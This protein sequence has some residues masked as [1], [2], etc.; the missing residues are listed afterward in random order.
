MTRLRMTLRSLPCAFAP[1]ITATSPKKTAQQTIS[2]H[3]GLYAYSRSIPPI[4][5]FLCCLT[6]VAPAFFH[7]QCLWQHTFPQS[8]QSP[9][10]L[11]PCCCCNVA[12]AFSRRACRLSGPCVTSQRYTVAGETPSCAAN[13]ATDS[14]C[15]LRSR[16]TD[17][18]VG[19]IFGVPVLTLAAACNVVV[20][21][22]G[23]G[24]QR[25]PLRAACG[26]RLAGRAAEAVLRPGTVRAGCR[27]L[28]VATRLV[29]RGCFFSGVCGAGCVSVSVS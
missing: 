24:S 21:G 13:W 10:R 2:V 7:P 18:P 5:R 22:C 17:L 8:T 12:K 29:A 11:W 28:V 3:L 4:A 6:I 27:V 14:P 19:R 20:V 23:A 9:R 15:L 25:L 26:K 16:A 1:R